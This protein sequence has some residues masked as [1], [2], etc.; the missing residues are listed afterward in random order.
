[1]NINTIVCLSGLLLLAG[2]SLIG[3][4][5]DSDNARGV[6]HFQTSA[7]GEAHREFIKGVAALHDFWYPQARVHF[8]KARK[9]DPDFAM[10]YWG[11]AM[12][13]D[14]PLWSRHEHEKGS[15]VLKELDQKVNA[16]TVKWSER[17][18]AYL[19]AVRVLYETGPPMHKRRDQYASAMAEL[20]EQYPD[21]QE[22]TVF[23]SLAAMSVN[24]FSFSA[25]SDVE[26]VAERLE[27]VIEQNPDHPGALHYLIHLYDTRKFA[28]RSLPAAERYME[29]AKSPHALHMPSHIFRH[30]G[31]WDKF[32]E[33]NK[34]AYEA[35]VQ[36]QQET[37]RP[38]VSRDFHAFTWL[39]DGYM[40]V[41]NFEEA[42][43]LLNELDQMIAKA[44]NR[45]E[46]HAH[47]VGKSESL[48]KLYN[49][50]AGAPVCE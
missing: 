24:G 40:K 23:E 45:G 37:G 26:P 47:L 21:D 35:S 41:E 3:D 29:I 6:V 50:Q 15:Q 19:D 2:C 34:A 42:C 10:A 22:V 48:G 27:S 38:L 36:W 33:S 13:H 7:S 14:H 44:R 4:P 1:M 17:E 49:E 12:T 25:E 32:I 11:E 43:K 16:G 46:D 39:F 28:Q 18:K 30:L 20:A 9:L 5:S 8:K 31:M